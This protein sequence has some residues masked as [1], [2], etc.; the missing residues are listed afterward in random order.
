MTNAG[1]SWLTIVVRAQTS[2]APD[3]RPWR[4]APPLRSRCSG[5]CVSCTFAGSA[6]APATA[7][8]P[9]RNAGS[10]KHE[11]RR[12][13]LQGGVARQSQRSEQDGHKIRIPLISEK[14]CRYLG[15][16]CDIP[17]MRTIRRA[18]QRPLFRLWWPETPSAP[19]KRRKRIDAHLDRLAKTVTSSARALTI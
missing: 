10:E 2:S 14:S 5:A 8:W 15:K 11:A 9:V 3:S 19:K 17:L 16:P 6:I 4:Q 18:F 13:G 7:L 12:G 1:S